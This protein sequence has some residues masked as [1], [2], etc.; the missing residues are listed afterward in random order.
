MLSNYNGNEKNPS[1][2]VVELPAH[3]NQALASINDVGDIQVIQAQSSTREVIRRV[4]QKHVS[5]HRFDW[6]S[7]L[8]SKFPL[9]R[10][11]DKLLLHYSQRW[12]REYV[13]KTR[14]DKEHQALQQRNAS[15]SASAAA[16][17]GLPSAAT[18][19]AINVKASTESVAMPYVLQ[20]NKLTIP[21]GAAPRHCRTSKCMCQFIEERLKQKSLTACG[22]TELFS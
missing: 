3:Y 22:L 18:I 6:R 2:T 1:S 8:T 7:C 20:Y 21:S 11:A 14:L 13:R 9:Q 4:S 5:F 15:A 10:Y 17:S 12:V 19:E 16:A